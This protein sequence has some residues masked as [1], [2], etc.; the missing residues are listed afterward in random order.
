MILADAEM[1]K[2]W[3]NVEQDLSELF[4]KIPDLNAI[5]LLIGIR[6]LGTVKTKFSKEE[7]VNLMHIAV[8]KLLSYSG[9]YVLEGTDKDGWPHWRS[10]KKLPFTNVLEQE[11]FIKHHVIEYFER[12]KK[13]EE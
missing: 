10:E 11:V 7:K 2:K 8:C 5:L 12:L 4:G 13:D 9:Y 6:E 3:K 1:A